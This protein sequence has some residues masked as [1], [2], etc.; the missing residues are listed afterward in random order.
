VTLITPASAARNGL[1]WIPYV[2]RGTETTG[3]KGY[4]D[5]CGCHL[6][7]TYH[8]TECAVLPECGDNTAY[9]RHLRKGE[10]PCAACRAAHAAKERAN[11]AR[12]KAARG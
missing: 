7:S 8:T 11:A 3:R 1:P 2:Y 10:A 4:C 5:N 12:R 6:S 9:E